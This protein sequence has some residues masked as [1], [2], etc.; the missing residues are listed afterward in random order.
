MAVNRV[1]T[2]V[3]SA[4]FWVGVFV[5]QPSLHKCCPLVGTIKKSMP[6]DS[7]ELELELELE[8]VHLPTYSNGSFNCVV[9]YLNISLIYSRF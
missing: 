5:P 6:M 2:I 7:L 9:L 4:V 8:L 1:H 3:Q